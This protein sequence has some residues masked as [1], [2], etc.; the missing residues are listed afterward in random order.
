MTFWQNL[1]DNTLQDNLPDDF[2]VGVGSTSKEIIRQLVTQPE[3]PWWNDS[4]TPEREIMDDIFNLTFEE[5]YRELKKD[6]EGS[7]RLA[8]GRTSYY[9]FPKSGHEQFPICQ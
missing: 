6:W 4:S 8:M 5:S 1:I 2:N 3:N 9:H 7:H